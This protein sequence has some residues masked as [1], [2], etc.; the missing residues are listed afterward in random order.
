MG[1]TSRAFNWFTA[2]LILHV[3]NSVTS[4]WA[5]WRLKS[6]ASRVFAWPFVQAQIRQNTKSPR[7]W[8][9]WGESTSDRCIPPKRANNTE[10]VSIWWCHHGDQKWFADERRS[11]MSEWSTPTVLQ[12]NTWTIADQDL[13]RHVASLGHT[14][15]MIESQLL[16]ILAYRIA[17][18][19]PS[20]QYS[21]I[22]KI[23]QPNIML[24]LSARVL[25]VARIDVSTCVGNAKTM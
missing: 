5:R 24:A 14:E 16:L 10:N 6:P 1:E 15:W 13:W 2:H 21:Y 9:L 12:V 25:Q 3:C 19:H 7:H 17:P 23:N 18:Y 20:S 8:P 22:S 11:I 4:Q